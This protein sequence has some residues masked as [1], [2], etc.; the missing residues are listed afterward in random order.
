MRNRGKLIVTVGFCAAWLASG[1]AQTTRTRNHNLSL[2]FEGSAE[3]CSD[4]KVTSRGGEVAQ[5]NEAFTIAKKE[6]PVLELT[7]IDRGVFKVRG[8]DRAEYSVETCKIAVA[9][10]RAAA[11]QA[12]RAVRV[13]RSGGR[14]SAGGPSGSDAN[15]QIYFIVRA[16]RDAN[17]D[18]ETTNGPIDIAG[19]TGMLK[20]RSTN[21]PI[22]LRDSSG[23]LDVNTNNGPI[24]FGGGG[25]EVHL[26]AQNGPISLDLAGDVWNGSKLEA[27][28]V[29]GPVSIAVSDT[30]H[31]GVRLETS[32][33]APLSCAIAACRSAWTDAGSD[34]RVLQLNGSQDT[35]RVSTTNGPVSVHGPKRRSII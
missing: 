20:V 9:E 11:E 13:S 5:A 28:T 29:N 8:W 34:Q 17:I 15:W 33:H 18:L 12:V 24:S 23:T 2:N 25:G 1:Q 27:K 31:S 7:N 3:H 19:V 26:A 35:V 10:D 32:G 4:L 14:F 21:G 16:P 6:A 30:F 22:S